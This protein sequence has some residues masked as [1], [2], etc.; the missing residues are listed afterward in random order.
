MEKYFLPGNLNANIERFVIHYNHHR[1]HE[2]LSNLTPADVYFG[3][4]LIILIERT[5]TI[6]NTINQQ[7]I[8]A[9]P[10][11]T[12]PSV[13]NILTNGVSHS[14][15]GNIDND[16]GPKLRKSKKVLFLCLGLLAGNRCLLT[17]I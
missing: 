3:R 7:I 12:P 10:S 9:L 14:V 17:V 11:T 13:P 15:I 4:G 1:Y 8:Q 2:S 6:R 16:K 5:R